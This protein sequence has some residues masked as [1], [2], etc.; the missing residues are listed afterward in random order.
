[1]F[2]E[3]CN[4]RLHRNSIAVHLLHLQRK[5]SEDTENE[6]SYRYCI[7][8]VVPV[9]YDSPSHELQCKN[10]VSELLSS[11]NENCVQLVPK[12]PKYSNYKKKVNFLNETVNA[13]RTKDKNEVAILRKCAAKGIYL[14][15][16]KHSI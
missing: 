5:D 4:L 14:C 10:L 12:Y 8:D 3:Y 16:H 2:S 6:G 9:E 11:G 15:Q 7:E 13:T 1:M